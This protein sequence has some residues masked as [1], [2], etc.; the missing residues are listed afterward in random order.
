MKRSPRKGSNLGLELRRLGPGHRDEE[1][2]PSEGIEPPTLPVE[3]ACTSVVLRRHGEPVRNRTGLTWVAIRLRHQ[4]VRAQ[5]SGRGYSKP[6]VHLG[7]VA[8]NLSNGRVPTCLYSLARK[9]E[10]GWR[11]SNPHGMGWKPS[12]L[13]KRHPHYRADEGT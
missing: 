9:C 4:T 8:S 2:V 6:H 10:S 3:A 1:R 13:P 12:S 11:G 5:Q 7:K